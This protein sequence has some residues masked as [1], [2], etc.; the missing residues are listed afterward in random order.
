MGS[1]LVTNAIPLVQVAV[2]AGDITT[3]Y[4]VGGTFT[5]AV[6]MMMIVS[7]L[8]A[9]VQISFD[10]TNDHIVVPAGNTVPVF[11][12][13]NFKDNRTVL[14]NPIIAVKQIG[15][16]TTGSLYVSAF[17]AYIP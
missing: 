2:A 3:E 9:E 5:S 15:E 13:F 17:S 14:P 11:M 16:P 6:V 1:L 12:P 8:D 4:T 10:G 7:T